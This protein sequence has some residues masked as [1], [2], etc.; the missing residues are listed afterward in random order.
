M[1]KVYVPNIPTRYDPITE[2]RVSAINLEPATK[3]GELVQLVPS[4]TDL[5]NDGISNA[6]DLLGETLKDYGPDDFVLSAGDP[7]L[8]AAAICYASDAAGDVKVLRWDRNN[9][10]YQLL[11]V[12]L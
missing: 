6:L 5:S 1:S 9:R 8:I 10:R 11:E 2:G 7:I 12:I 3:F 4:D